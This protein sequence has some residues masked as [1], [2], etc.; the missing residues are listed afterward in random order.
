LFSLF[1]K[2]VFEKSRVKLMAI[3]RAK[4]VRFELI[5]LVLILAWDTC[6]LYLEII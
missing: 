5:G 6:K 2:K 4:N 1:V 3:L